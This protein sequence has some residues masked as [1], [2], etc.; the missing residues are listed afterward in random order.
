VPEV[1]RILQALDGPDDRIA[2]HLAWSRFRRK[3]QEG[4]RRCHRARWR[5]LSDPTDAA[6]PA[7]RLPAPSFPTAAA[8]GKIVALLTPTEPRVGR[9]PQ[10][11]RRILTA[12]LWVM[13]S[14]KRWE[15]LP[16][17]LGNWRTVYSHHNR[18]RTAGTWQSILGILRTDEL[19]TG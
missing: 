18:W 15:D 2:F 16:P 17:E 1:R 10:D 3:H 7:I 8:W 5:D 4:A 13:H 19:D 11:H 6:P 14:G 12:I 9:K